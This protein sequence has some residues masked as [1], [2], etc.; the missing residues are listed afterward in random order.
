MKSIRIHCPGEKRVTRFLQEV[1]CILHGRIERVQ[2]HPDDQTPHTPD[3]APGNAAHPHPSLIY[4]H[5]P[6]CLYLAWI[7]T[8]VL[9]R[10]NFLRPWGLQDE[11]QGRRVARTPSNQLQ[12]SPM[13]LVPDLA[14]IRRAREILV[15]HLPGTRTTL[16][17]SLSRNGSTV[18]LKLETE[19]PTGSFKPRGAIYALA[20]NLGRR[21]IAEVDRLQHRQPRC[22]RC[23]RRQSPRHSCHDLSALEPEPGQARQDS[24]PR[25]PHRRERRRGP[26][27][28][29]PAGRGVFP[30]PWN[31]FPE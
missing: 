3:D 29:F 5:A 18:H 2:L 6:S 11:L 21:K 16:A 10:V 12:S 15:R 17:R 14:T 30:R 23:V 20:I 19:L 7:G 8:S 1:A 26:G 24:G 22:R 27:P 9:L 25:R 28:R 13:A 4:L 31:L